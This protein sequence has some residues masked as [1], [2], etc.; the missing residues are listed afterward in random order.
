LGFKL[1]TEQ[2]QIIEMFWQVLVSLDIC[3][4]KSKNMD[5]NQCMCWYSLNNTAAIPDQFEILIDNLTMYPICILSLLLSIC[6]RLYTV[7]PFQ[8]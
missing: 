1:K 6:K 3:L 5:T 8:F 2:L 4:D 7:Q